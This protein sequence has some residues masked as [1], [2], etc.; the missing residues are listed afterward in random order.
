MG[1]RRRKPFIWQD[2]KE[3]ILGEIEDARLAAASDELY[4]ALRLLRRTVRQLRR[5]PLARRIDGR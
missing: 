2:H 5:N 3:E 1:R 4:V